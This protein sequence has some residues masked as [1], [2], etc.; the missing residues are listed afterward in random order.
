MEVI[1]YK[2]IYKKENNTNNYLKIL[3]EEFIKNNRN[4]GLLIINNKKIKFPLKGI[5]S[6]DEIK[7][8]TIKMILTK[9]ISNKS[10]LFNNCES[11]ES[12]SQL[13]FHDNEE[14]KDDNKDNNKYNKIIIDNKQTEIFN[15][16]DNDFSYSGTYTYKESFGTI[17]EITFNQKDILNNK[18]INLNEK[19][20]ILGGRYP[21]NKSSSYNIS[22]LNNIFIT[23]MSYMFSNLIVNH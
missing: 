6:L 2:I 12:I 16:I 7:K 19:Y 8:S 14:I 20:Y 3:G 18:F 23:D 13:F 4:K 9:Y 5:I 10:Y 15:S 21:D 22:E 1:L 17:S 11:L